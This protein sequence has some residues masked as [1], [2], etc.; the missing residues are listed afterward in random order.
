MR[1][2]A[3]AKID[4]SE[5]GRATVFRICGALDEQLAGVLVDSVREAS[6]G[7]PRVLVD[8][9]AVTSVDSAGL[10]ALIRGL[11]AARDGGGQLVLARPS[12]EVAHMLQ[13]TGLNQVLRVFDG[14]EAALR[15]LEQPSP[16]ST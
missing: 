11:K 16:S 13:L 15:F 3:P 14:T 8:L 7:S 6:D 12:A 4:R 1:V 2:T 10:G 5:S 9:A